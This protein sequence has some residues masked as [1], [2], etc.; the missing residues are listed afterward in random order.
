MKRYYLFA[1]LLALMYVTIG[2][3]QQYPMMDM[4]AR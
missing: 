1:L 4:I 2:N 3:A